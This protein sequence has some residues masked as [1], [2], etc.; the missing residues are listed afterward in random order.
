MNFELTDEQ[1]LIAEKYRTFAE[2]ELAARAARLDES[3]C[4]K[5]PGLMRENLKKVAGLG[6]FGLIHD[7]AC[8]GSGRGW[9]TLAVAGE[10]IACACPSTYLSSFAS[11]CLFGMPLG[12]FGS[13]NQKRKYLRGIIAGDLV[14]C[15][16]LVE[17]TAE[18]DSVAVTVEAVE[19]GNGWILRGGKPLITNAPIADVF[20]VPA[21]T[22]SGVAIFIVERNRPGL[23]ISAP[24]EKMGYRGSPTADIAFENC[25]VPGSAVLGEAGKGLVQI[26]KVLNGGRIGMA[27]AS[28]GI[29]A[30]CLEESRRYALEKKSDGTPIGR[31]QEVAFKLADMVIMTDLSRLLIYRACWALDRDDPDST[32]LA[33]C[34]KVFAAETAVQSANLTM[35]ISGGEGYLRTSVVERLYRDAKLGDICWGTSELHRIYVGTEVLAGFRAEAP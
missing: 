16:V 30:A 17:S 22:V 5:T 26:K 28:L 20:L 3:P 35:Q 18:E 8:S 24:L 1:K 33:A 13:E 12:R 14:G 23:S 6:F 15:C 11:A 19:T 2:T 29:A 32:V 25:S 31:H 10:A 21:R 7:P 4:E 34:A 9:V 27:V